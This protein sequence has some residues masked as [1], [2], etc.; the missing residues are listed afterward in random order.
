MHIVEK[1]QDFGGLPREETGHTAVI[2]LGHG[3]KAAEANDAMY[4]VVRRLQ[5]R[6]PY[7]RF[8]AA[9]LEI[10]AP[11]VPEGIDRCAEAGAE[12]ILLLPYFLHL[13]NHVQKDLPGFMEEGRQRHPGL[14]ISLG[15]HLGFHGKLVEIVEDRLIESLAESPPFGLL[16]GS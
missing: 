12:R 13:G 4:E 3:S 9:F 11:S 5:E 2:L 16:P 10:N 6:W 14:E 1:I 8:S 15:P 7:Y